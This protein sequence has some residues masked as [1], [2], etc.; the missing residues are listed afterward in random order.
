[1]SCL[2]N[3]FCGIHTMPACS[4]RL[5]LLRISYPVAAVNEFLALPSVLGSAADS[6]NTPLREFKGAAV[7]C[8]PAGRFRADFH[9]VYSSLIFARQAEPPQTDVAVR[10]WQLGG[11][12]E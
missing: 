9:K 12:R 2:G 3:I 7:L 10:R 6:R 8:P 4:A 11:E 5:L 1:M